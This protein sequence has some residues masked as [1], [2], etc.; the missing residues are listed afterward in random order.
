MNSYLLMNTKCQ[1][2]KNVIVHNKLQLEN[3]FLNSVAHS[4]KFHHPYHLVDPS[5]WPVLT[6]LSVLTLTIGMVLYFHKYSGGGTVLSFGLLC[7]V[8]NA[9]VWWR[10][11]IRESRLFLHTSKVKHGL[12]L[13]ML[14]FIVTEA[15]FFVGMLWAFLNAAL[16]PTVY[17]GIL[18]CLK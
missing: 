9:I 8:Y 2:R 15:M 17:V 10:D 5:P 13:G 12:H 16:M 4:S 18:S 7:V 3:R 1:F 14:L 11:V 6:S